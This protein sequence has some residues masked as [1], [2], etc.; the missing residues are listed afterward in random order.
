MN[1]C[2]KR[3]RKVKMED[4]CNFEPE[5]EFMKFIL[6]TSPVLEELEVTRSED[7]MDEEERRMWKEVMRFRRASP[8]AQVI[9]SS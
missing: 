8:K 1:C 7:T 9:Y 2:L 5:L 3:L 6:A 4:V